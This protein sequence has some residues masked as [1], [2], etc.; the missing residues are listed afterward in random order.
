M[1]AFAAAFGSGVILG[2]CSNVWQ[3]ADRFLMPR[4]P[5]QPEKTPLECGVFSGCVRQASSPYK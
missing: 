4:K 3:R 5:L 2:R 1:Y